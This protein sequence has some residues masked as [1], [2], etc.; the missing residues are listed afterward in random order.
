[1]RSS[2]ALAGVDL[3]EGRLRLAL[4]RRHLVGREQLP[5]D[6]K[7]E[8]VEKRFLFISYRERRHGSLILSRLIQQR[9][10]FAHQLLTRSRRDPRMGQLVST[11]LVILARRDV[12]DTAEVVAQGRDE[13]VPIR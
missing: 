6:E 2:L 4:D 12:A 9:H 7:A 13:Q 1:M 5:E 8:L 11:H 10:R 3:V